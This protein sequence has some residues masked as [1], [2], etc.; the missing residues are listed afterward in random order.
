MGL[1]RLILWA[2]GFGGYRVWYFWF[3]GDCGAGF[4]S[5]GLWLQALR[6]WGLDL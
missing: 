3:K 6:V 5:L 4:S 2:W 1:V